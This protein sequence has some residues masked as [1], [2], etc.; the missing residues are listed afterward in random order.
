VKSDIILAKK[1]NK[2]G[3]HSGDD[4]NIVESEDNS[5]VIYFTS[6]VDTE[7]NFRLNKKLREK[8]VEL[9][10]QSLK[11]QT[12]LVPIRLYIS[13]YGGSL[14][15]AFSTIDCIKS[16]DTPVDTYIDQSTASAG[17][18]M[19]VVGRNRYIGENSYMLIHQLSGW[20]CGTYENMKDNIENNKS[21]MKKILSIYREHTMIPKKKLKE[22][23]KRDLW[24]DA[25]TCLKYGLVDDII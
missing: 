11:Q 24:L 14:L 9:R 17:T 5:N 20:S 12:N 21:F 2:S 13:T 18:L 10:I 16:L 8:D 25:R 23:L 1:S 7:N 19:S 3:S 22:I 6:D 4:N 15:S